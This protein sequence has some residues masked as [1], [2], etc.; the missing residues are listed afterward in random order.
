MWFFVG[1]DND[2]QLSRRVG[3]YLRLYLIGCEF[4]PSEAVGF[5]FSVVVVVCVLCYASLWVL[6]FTFC[7]Y[8][9]ACCLSVGDV[10]L[11]V[12][13]YLMGSVVVLA[14]EFSYSICKIVFSPYLL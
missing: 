6:L 13:V 1:L 10:L 12:V 14:F 7:H 8:V 3:I 9:G 2:V 11:E 5:D 4:D